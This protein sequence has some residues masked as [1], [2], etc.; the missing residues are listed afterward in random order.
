M[1]KS[2]P[3]CKAGILLV[4]ALDNA[5]FPRLILWGAWGGG[6]FIMR[7]AA[8]KEFLRRY[9]QAFALA[10]GARNKLAPPSRTLDERAFLPAV[11]ELQESPPHPAARLTLWMLITLLVFVLLWSVFGKTDVVAVARGKLVVSARSKV[12]QPLQPSIV[13]AIHVKDGQY[14]EAGQLLIELDPTIAGAESNKVQTAWVEARLEALRSQALIVALDSRRVPVLAHDPELAAHPLRVA[15]TGKL[16]HSQWQEFQSK[17]ATI[18]ADTTRKHA[19]RDGVREQV[20]KL[21]Q[22]LPLIAQR[23]ANYKDLSDKNFVSRHGYLEKEQARIEAERNLSS[24]RKKWDELNGGIQ[25]NLRQREAIQ[26]EFRRTQ[27]DA[28]VRANEKVRELTQELVKAGQVH[29]QTKLVAPAS[30]VVQQLVVRSEGGVVTEAQPLLVV[31]PRE[32]AIE[33]EVFVENKD[34][35]FVRA[36][37]QAAVKI[38]TFD[39]TRYG[40]LDGS[41]ETVSLDAIQDEK[42]GLIYQTKVMLNKGTVMIDGKAVRLTPGMAVTVEIKTSQRRII[43]YF[44]SPLIRYGNESLR[45]R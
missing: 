40:F 41:V 12:V 43:E 17:L 13:K 35:G 5:V 1:R 44:L 6:W 15:D 20:L 42:R 22:T 4:F 28:L 29:R 25:A 11:L 10:W 32:E 3:F 2:P 18:D 30:G 7:F 26:A 33:A 21:E 38:D 23:A 27:H 37:Q 24:Q 19:E 8:Y 34:I 36:G 14:V 31:V 45:E 16:M 39:Y 9:G